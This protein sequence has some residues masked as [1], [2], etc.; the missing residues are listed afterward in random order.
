[1]IQ[2]FNEE[3]LKKSAENFTKHLAEI[4]KNPKELDRDFVFSTLFTPLKLQEKEIGKYRI[5]KEI[6]KKGEILTVVSE[7][8]WIMMGYKPLRVKLLIDRAIHKLKREGRMLMSDTPQEMFLQYKAVEKAKGKVLTSGLGLGMFALMTAKKPQVESITVVEIDKDVIKLIG[9]K[10]PKIKI[11]KGDIWDFI[12]KT[13]EKFDYAYIDIH[14]STGAMEYMKT[15]LPMR[16]IL[17]K[18]FPNM[19]VDFWGEEEMKPQ[20]HEGL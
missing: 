12:K 15:V 10:H 16:K 18:R 7:R 14:Y 11:I 13:K 20:Y 4:S 8:N 19:P 9:L 2:K 3:Q 1:M 17:N 5:E 6:K